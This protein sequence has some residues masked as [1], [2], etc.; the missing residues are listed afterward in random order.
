MLFVW[1]LKR[2][3]WIKPETRQWAKPFQTY[4]SKRKAFAG[5]PA[6]CLQLYRYSE[7]SMVHC[8]FHHV[9]KVLLDSF[10]V[11]THN[12]ASLPTRDTAM[13]SYA[14]AYA[15]FRPQSE[16]PTQHQEQFHFCIN[17]FID[18]KNRYSNRRDIPFVSCCAFV[19]P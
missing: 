3:R 16:Q 2:L 10:Q 15:N 6:S 14:V 5:L 8:P 19:T 11:A 1:L 7:T 9:L 17:S 4:E 18:E 12:Y 13:F